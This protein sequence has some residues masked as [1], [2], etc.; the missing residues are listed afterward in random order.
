MKPMMRKLFVLLFPL[1]LISG[2]A[3]GKN[4]RWFHTRAKVIELEPVFTTINTSGAKKRCQRPVRRI[5]SS[6]AEDIRQ[7]ERKQMRLLACEA[8]A[9]PRHQITGYWVTYEYQGHQGRKYMS[10]KPGGWIPVTVNLQ[11]LQASRY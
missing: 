1:V 4:H 9:I 2:N 8:M 11:P 10:E 5:A 6:M 3:I 7:Q